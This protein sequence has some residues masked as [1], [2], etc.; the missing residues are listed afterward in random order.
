MTDEQQSCG[1]EEGWSIV[2][3]IMSIDVDFF[4][5]R[6]LVDENK[7]LVPIMTNHRPTKDAEKKTFEINLE[8]EIINKTIVK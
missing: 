3:K 6:C 1:D 5:Y 8:D 4:H 7:D 2:G